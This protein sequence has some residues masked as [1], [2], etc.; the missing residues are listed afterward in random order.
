MSQ[1]A[2]VQE[3]HSMSR[4]SSEANLRQRA[5]SVLI[6]LAWLASFSAVVLACPADGKAFFGIIGAIVVSV[7]ST[8]IVLSD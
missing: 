8:A 7:F 2:T 6:I 3:T 1:P 4:R 5:A